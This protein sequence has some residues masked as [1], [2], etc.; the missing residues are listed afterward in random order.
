MLLGY[1]I[2]TVIIYI[3]GTKI[4]YLRYKNVLL[5]NVIQNTQGKVFKRKV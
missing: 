3:L 4:R 2:V 1:K 5:E